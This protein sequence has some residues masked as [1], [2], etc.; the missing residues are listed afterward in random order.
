MKYYFLEP[1]IAGGLGEKTVL[2][3]ST[4]PPKVDKLHYKFS[5]WLGDAILESFPCVI[6]TQAASD[7]LRHNGVTGVYF[8]DMETSTSTEFGEMYPQRE[9]PPFRWLQVN[10]IPGRDDFG[11]ADDL[12]L[13]V[14]E[15]VLDVLRPFGIQHALIED[16]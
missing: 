2:D 10:G 14:S 4:H 11:I 16:L 13:V 7:A 5:G 8:A 1:E 15:K 6:A 9:L 12:R 3:S